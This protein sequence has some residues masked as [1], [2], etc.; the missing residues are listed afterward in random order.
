L[1]PQPAA[2]KPQVRWGEAARGP[3][4]LAGGGEGGSATSRGWG[5]ACGPVAPAGVARPA[6]GSHPELGFAWH[7]MV[8]AQVVAGMTPVAVWVRLPDALGQLGPLACVWFRGRHWP[9]IL[10]TADHPKVSTV[11]QTYSTS[12]SDCKSLQVDVHAASL[13]RGSRA[14]RRCRCQQALHIPWYE[15]RPSGTLVQVGSPQSR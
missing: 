6:Q 8:G 13:V 11:A 10:R 15:G 2:R 5:W 1:W 7:Q 14:Q 3:S 12:V 4:G 9:P